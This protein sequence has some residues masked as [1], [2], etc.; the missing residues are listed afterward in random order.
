MN[1]N[2]TANLYRVKG[3]PF[4]SIFVY[5]NVFIPRN[6][7]DEIGKNA[8]SLIVFLPKPVNPVFPR[9]ITDFSRLPALNSKS[10]AR[11]PK[12]AVFARTRMNSDS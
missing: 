11:Y 6:D 7:N 3:Y 9:Q 10:D 4:L 2:Y 12:N 5:N 1:A 8:K